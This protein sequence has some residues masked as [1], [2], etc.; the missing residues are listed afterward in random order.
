MKHLFAVTLLLALPFAAIAADD[1]WKDLFNGKDLTGW[2]GLEGY[3]SVKDGAITGYTKDGKLPHGNTFLIWDGKVADF[4]LKCKWKLNGGNSG[5]QY[6]SKMIGDPK[7]FV[8]GG[9]QADI[10][11]SGPTKAGYLGILY[12]EQ[13]RGIVTNR[14]SRTWITDDGAKHETAIPQSADYLKSVKVGDW[15]D[16]T[17]VAKANHLFHIVNGVVSAETID[18]QTSKRAAEGLLAL[19]LHA[20][21]EMTVQFKEIKLKKL[22]G[23]EEV[24]LE[25]MPIPKNAKVS[26]GPKPKK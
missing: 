3:W 15:N 13:G 14:A 1:E 8:V 24:T 4:E 6:R 21:S 17:I 19:Q 11:P 12:E 20:G 22:T 7:K 18:L 10:D 23:N 25:K 16:Y 2:S 5:I 26:G 9:Y